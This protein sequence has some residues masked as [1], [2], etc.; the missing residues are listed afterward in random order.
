MNLS[1]YSKALN[2]TYRAANSGNKYTLEYR[3]AWN[4]GFME[5]VWRLAQVIS[6]QDPDFNI[7][8]FLNDVTRIV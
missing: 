4:N 8:S 1:E 5:A 2:K 3:T 6:K 7:N